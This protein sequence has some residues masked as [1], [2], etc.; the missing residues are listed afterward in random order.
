MITW[1]AYFNRITEL[2]L[3]FKT[4]RRALQRFRESSE[5]VRQYAEGELQEIRKLV[6]EGARSQ[7]VDPQSTWPYNSESAAKYLD[8][9]TDSALRTLGDFEGRLQQYEFILRVTIFEGL[10]KDIHRE[11]LASYPGLL[12]EDRQVPLGKLVANGIDDVLREEI[13]REVQILDRKSTAEKAEYFVKRLGISWFDGT[14]VPILDKAIKARNEMLHENPDRTPT[15]GEVLFMELATM[16]VPTATL[17]QAAL[18]Y[19]KT[20]SLPMSMS[21][22]DAKKFLPGASNAV[23]GEREW[24][25]TA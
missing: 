5:A 3:Q 11:I 13:D 12:K 9:A 17:A 21:E 4:A 18:L 15:R 2:H 24:H 19:P 16:S 25:G 22:E 14:I 1:E 7:H 8:A 23:K 20:C 10:M 6:D